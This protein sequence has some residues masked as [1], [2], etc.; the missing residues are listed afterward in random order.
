MSETIRFISLE[1]TAHSINEQISLLDK[2]LEEKGMYF[3]S[4]NVIDSGI[5]LTYKDVSQKAVSYDNFQGGSSSPWSVSSS[6]LIP[7]TKE[8]E[9]TVK[10]LRYIKQLNPDFEEPIGFT[11]D[12]A[13]KTIAQ[14][15]NNK[16]K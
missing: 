11:K 14:L 4:Y 7:N 16:N 10:Q 3:N 6:D 13:R 2:E 5:I 12:D 1:D 9:P 15:K 8:E